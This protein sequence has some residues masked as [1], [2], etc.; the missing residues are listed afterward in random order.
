MFK[1]FWISVFLFGAWGI[2][3]NLIGMDHLILRLSLWYASGFIAGIW[4]PPLYALL[5]GRQLPGCFIAFF[6]PYAFFSIFVDLIRHP[7]FIR[8]MG[9]KLSWDI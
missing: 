6:W 7:P 8:N 1:P 2:F 4:A 3:L 9:D 5:R